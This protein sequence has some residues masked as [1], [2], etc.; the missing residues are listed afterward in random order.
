MYYCHPERSEGY[1]VIYTL[2]QACLPDRQAQGD[3]KIA[4]IVQQHPYTYYPHLS[5]HENE[6]FVTVYR[7][8]ID[9]KMIGAYL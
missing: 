7:C 2:R 4:T 1:S 3:K 6:W 5:V 9:T 8:I